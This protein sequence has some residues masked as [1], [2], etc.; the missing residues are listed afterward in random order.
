M[1]HVA[2]EML[3]PRVC[4]TMKRLWNK[5]KCCMYVCWWWWWR[6]GGRGVTMKKKKRSTVRVI[7]TVFC[8][9]ACLLLADGSVTLC[10]TGGTRWLHASCGVPPLTPH[11][12]LPAPSPGVLSDK[13]S[14]IYIAET[15][16]ILP[17]RLLTTNNKLQ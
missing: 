9:L 13:P 8:A 7:H 16:R 10:S 15:S 11:S 2:V 12:P 1:R 3:V 5:S 17:N 14:Q 4:I 6:S